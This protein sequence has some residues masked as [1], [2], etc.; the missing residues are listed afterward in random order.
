MALQFVLGGSGSGK[1]EYVQKFA[2]DKARAN[3]RNNILMI[4]PDQFTMQTQWRMAN[5]HPDGG[6]INIDVLS[7]SRLPRKVFEEVGVPKRILLDDTGKCLLIKRGASK[8]KDE[9]HI[10]SRGMNNA[11][12]SGEVKS[13]ISEFMQ[14]NVTPDDIEDYRKRCNNEVLRSK[15]SDL[16]LLY[17][18]FLKECEERYIT[19]EEMLDLFIERLPLSQKVA[20]SILI[21]DGFT[22]FTPIQIKAIVA[23]LKHSEDVIIT[24]PFDNDINENPS[25]I[26]AGNY[27]FDLT[28]RNMA[29]L[30]RECDKNMIE[31]KNNIRLTTDHRHKDNPDLAF[32]E[33]N[34][35]RNESVK[36]EHTD[37]IKIF[38]CADIENE[39]HNMCA[40]L[41]KEI[42]ENDLRYRDVAF[43]CADMPKYQKPLKKYL[44]RYNIPY[45]MDSNRTIINNPL[46]RYIDSVTA[47]LKNNFKPE[48][49]VGFLRNTVSPFEDEEVDCLENYI[50][51]R[52]IKG[53]SKWKKEF[54]YKSEE[55]KIN[56]EELDQMN[57][58]RERFVAL[59]GDAISYGKGKRTLNEW[60]SFIYD[61]LEKSFAYDKLKAKSEEFASLSRTEDAMEYDSI[62]N[63]VIELFDALN[64]LMGDEELNI[65][66]FSDILKVGFSEI[67]VGIL[68]QKVDSLLVGD[69]QRTRLKEIRTL[70]ILGVN[71]GNIPKS[72]ENSGLLSLP[73]KEELKRLDCRLAPTSDELAFIEQLYIYLN[74]TKPTDKLYLSFA[75]IGGKGEKLTPSY[76]VDILKNMYKDMEIKDITEMR[77]KIF[78]SDIKEEAGRLLGKYA[79]GLTSDEDEEILF[80]DIRILRKSPEGK[81]WIERMTE[82]AFREYSMTPL[83]KKIAK[84]L[85]GDILTVSVSTLEQFAGCQYAYFAIYGLE[86]KEREIY[87]LENT[88]MG[89]LSHDVLEEVGKK[90]KDDDRD[91][92][93]V[94]V[95][96]L[97]EQID[98][99]IEK[100]TEEYNGDILRSDEKTAY[101]ARQ[102]SR[103]MKRTVKTLGFQLS[104]GR[105]R[106]ESYEMRFKKMY[107]LSDDEYK[108]SDVKHVILKGRI[109]RT[110]I[111]DDG[112][113]NKY[114]KIIDYKSSGR[115]FDVQGIKEGTSLQ[116]AIYMKNVIET[117]KQ[118]YPK[119]NIF[120]AAMLYYAI[121]DPFADYGS[122]AEKEIRKALMPTGAIVNDDKVLESLDEDLLTPGTSSE[123][124]PV[125]RNKDNNISK[126][127]SVYPT[128]E[129]LNLLK[130]AQDKALSL[131][132]EILSGNI[133]VNPI[134]SGNST[135]CDHCALKGICGFDSK[136]AGYAYRDRS[137][138]G[139]EEA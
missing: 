78:I 84:D 107:D 95:G 2:I 46:V 51:A 21:F 131:S 119:D 92:S 31:V 112:N 18:V 99:A 87:G 73:D 93:N 11:G 81:E 29:D 102:L 32:L 121:D 64:D 54:I 67:R 108:T 128:D 71:D 136:I 123:A 58:L 61:I 98:L 69:M 43:I 37:R 19:K 25:H 90:I 17:E 138:E 100:L 57:S 77:P 80:S 6:I 33:K 47:I 129:F 7:F 22:G 4:V 66:E 68:P 34:L 137:E 26:T 42:E 24:L 122:D 111:Y 39:C 124:V 9:L 134:K 70:F 75:S 89:N 116:L 132:K 125:K 105:F 117:L 91:F 40:T 88:D 118:R 50:Y 63:K 15:L 96:I 113:G 53:L 72:S 38:K 1:S 41:L 8:V 59:F 62:Y 101:Y 103:I 65:K 48:D 13:V 23:L 106:P 135:A 133:A 10:L 28:K 120:P 55:L 49:T 20:K 12:W 114:V 74:L 5:A 115:R 139:K 82:N 16:K 104:K 79:A 56:N 86:L 76:L 83:D 3:R 130:E 45:Y 97:E 94:P 30:M 44:E 52:G 35:F 27:L 36:E 110:D 126:T 14:Y 60:I 109:D 127:S 85:Y